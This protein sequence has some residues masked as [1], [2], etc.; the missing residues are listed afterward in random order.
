MDAL[1]AVLTP[2]ALINSMS[3]L[4][5]GIA[6]VVTSLRT[7]KPNLTA[8]AFIAGKFV[9]RLAFGL[10]LVIGLDTAVDRV[11]VWMQDMWRDPVVL[12]V[13]LQL[14]IGGAMVVFGYRLSNARQQRS[15]YASSM[16]MTP[17]RAFSIA[18]SVAI[19]GLPG[20]L[21]YFA[22]IDQIL[23]A[24]S[25]VLGIMIALLYYNLICLL[26]LKLIVLARP[27]LGTRSDPIFAAVSRFFDRWGKRLMF[28]GLLGLG[29]VLVVDAVGWFIGFPLLRY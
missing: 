21:L 24:D 11:N 12:L 13:V 8:S 3:I 22:A 20:A 19:I 17:V 16:P 7:P 2:I 10:L 1:L 5:S 4:P 14:V 18:A 28:F 29:V 15:D 6:G 26:P 27:L 9:P 23:R 25:T